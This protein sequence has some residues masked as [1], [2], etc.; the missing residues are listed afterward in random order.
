MRSITLCFCLIGFM[1]A[2]LRS[3]LPPAANDDRKPVPLAALLLRTQSFREGVRSNAAAEI[4]RTLAAAARGAN[5]GTNDLGGLLEGFRALQEL[6]DSEADTG[7]QLSNAEA[8]VQAALAAAVAS[9]EQPEDRAAFLD[10]LDVAAFRSRIE[11]E[12]AALS[13]L[14]TDLRQTTRVLRRAITVAAALQ[15]ILP[16]DQLSS[17][18]TVRLRALLSHWD[19]PSSAPQQVVVTDRNTQTGRSTGESTGKPAPDA[20]PPSA[21]AA[22]PPG[23]ASVMRM[24]QAGVPE[25]I[26]VA[27]ISQ[28]DEPFMLNADLVLYAHDKGLTDSA[29]GAMLQ[30][31]T[32]L[33]TGMRGRSL[34]K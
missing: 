10:H 6:S 1:P 5:L 4:R 19:K 2:E 8:R 13:M 17:R 21:L 22:L 31:D 32:L 16:P 24:S 29:I 25:S 30:R 18:I 7:R 14:E 15:D 27:F 23:L 9:V 26:L 12:R 3:A 11:M 20:R 34:A 28:S 33:R